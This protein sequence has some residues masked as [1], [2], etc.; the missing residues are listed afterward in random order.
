[1][2]NALH[3]VEIVHWAALGIMGLVYTIR[4]FW[5]FKFNAGRDRQLPGDMGRTDMGPAMYS[6]F[7]V[8]MP[9]AMESTRGGKGFG[10]WVSFVLFHIGV[11]AG[12]FLAIF[13]SLMPEFF[14]DQTVA[15]VFIGILGVSFIVGLGRIFR[16]LGKP[17]M[18]LI[19]TPD[20]YFSLFMITGWF[21]TGV[22]AQ[23]HIGGYLPNPLYLIIFLAATSFFLIYVPFSKI[24]HYLYYPF[25]RYYIG[26]TLGHRGSMPAPRG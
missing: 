21:L 3:T 14:Q 23:A 9:W 7:N 12:I 25:I 20:D 24:S 18:R 10:F 2:E 17:V 13:S 16:R 11:V 6:M 1:M 19:S 5:L 26:K 8:A 4:L 15:Q 22:L